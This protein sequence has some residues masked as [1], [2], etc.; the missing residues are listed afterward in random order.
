VTGLT[1]AYGD[2]VAVEDFSAT[3][4]AG[5]LTVLSG[6]SGSGKSTIVAA[7]NGFVPAS[8]GITVDGRQI[9]SDRLA[10]DRAWLAWAG[11][12]PGLIF[13]TVAENLALGD[14]QPDEPLV[15]RSL[16]R[17]AIAELDPRLELGVGGSGVSGGQAQRVAIARALYRLESRG[18]RVLILDEP[19][20]ALDHATE[21]RLI[22]GLREVARAGVAVIVVSHRQ[23]FLTVADTVVAVAPV[24]AKRVTARA[25][26]GATTVGPKGTER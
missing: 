21:A 18:C 2:A 8:G 3:F 7:V 24:S 25:R 4:A 14:A 22:E 17:A 9:A 1:V 26:T 13:G 6:P 5:S 10:D 15:R 16:R 19:S 12:K 23:A 11:Q 20:S